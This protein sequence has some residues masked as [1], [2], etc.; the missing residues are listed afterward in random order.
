MTL[1]PPFLVFM[2]LT[3]LMITG[4]FYRMSLILGLSDI[5]SWIRLKLCFFFFFCLWNATEVMLHP[6]EYIISRSMWYRDGLLLILTLITSLG[7]CLP[8]LSPQSYYFSLCNWWMS[9]IV[10]D[11]AS[12]LFLPKLL[13]SD[14]SIYWK[15]LPA[16][17]IT[18]C[19]PNG[20]FMFPSFSLIY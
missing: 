1:I 2:T 6:S 5:F 7:W 3:L 4:S 16:R 20:D 12:I 9:W 17:V 11:Y 19:L 15:V 10:G 18:M 13:P 8:G 14:F